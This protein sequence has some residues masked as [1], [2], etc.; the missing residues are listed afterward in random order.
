MG[1]GLDGIIFDN[2]EWPRTRLSRSLYIYKS[3][4]S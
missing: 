3:N 4:I 1:A 2:L